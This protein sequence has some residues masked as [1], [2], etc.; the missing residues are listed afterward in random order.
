MMTPKY[1]QLADSLRTLIRDGAFHDTRQLPTEVQL[2]EQYQV[3]RQTVR[4]ALGL[5]VSEG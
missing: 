1:V 4:Q 5:L 3:S 2:C